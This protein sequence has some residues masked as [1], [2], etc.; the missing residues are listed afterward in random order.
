MDS[1]VTPIAFKQPYST[2]IRPPWGGRPFLDQLLDF[3]FD[4]LLVAGRQRGLDI[5]T[6]FDDVGQDIIDLAVGVEADVHATAVGRIKYALV[7]GLENRA[8]DSWRNH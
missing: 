6:D 1:L 8:E 5:G 3:V 4:L 7:L 2:P